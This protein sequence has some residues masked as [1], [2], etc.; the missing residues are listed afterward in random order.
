MQMSEGA[1]SVSSKHVLRSYL[2]LTALSTLAASL[3]W[4]VNTLFLLDAGLN[5]AQA[6]T[7]NAFFTA[8]QVLFEIPT[9]VVADTRG[10]RTSYLWGA[11]TLLIST[12]L[13]VWMW[14]A[15]APLWA[16]AGGSILIGLGFTFFFSGAVEAWLVD[17][18]D[19]TGHEGDLDSVFGRGQTVMGV[20]MLAGSVV[21][22]FLA[23]V[24]NLGVPYIVRAGLLLLVIVV[25]ARSMHDIGF[26]PQR[27]QAREEIRRIWAGSIEGGFKNPPVRWLMLAAPF[28]MGTGIYIFY[29]MQSYLLELYGDNTAFGIAGVA[30]A[31]VAGAQIAG[32]LLVPWVRR[33]FKRRTDAMLVAFTIGVVAVL[34]IGFVNNFWAALALIV[35]WALTF[36]TIAPVRQAYINGSIDSQQRA[37]VLSF[38][39]LMGSSG[40]VVAQPALG[41]AADVW[42]YSTS[43]VIAGLISTAALP[44]LFLAKRENAPSDRI[45]EQPDAAAADDHEEPV[46]DAP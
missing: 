38:D 19:A 29:A 36:S 24:T 39:A 9:G 18:L 8:G 5:N 2:T 31:I 16:W 43:Y 25:A 21:G 13:Y 14:Q 3:I 37:T 23:Q 28:M 44:F 6:F 27:G 22:G 11:G 34:L 46:T 10:R 17:A 20:A 33:R 41:R 40:G 35:V 42:S 45:E 1:P 26:E 4:G 12:L 32:G 7:V 15:S 30:A